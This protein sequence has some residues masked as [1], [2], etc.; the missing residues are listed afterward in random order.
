MTCSTATAPVKEV[1]TFSKFGSSFEE[2]KDRTSDKEVVS[3]L[4]LQPW[5]VVRRRTQV[6]PRYCIV[7]G[8]RTQV[9]PRYCIVLKC[10]QWH[11]LTIVSGELETME[12]QPTVKWNMKK[13]SLGSCLS[14]AL[15]PPPPSL[16]ESRHLVNMELMCNSAFF[17]LS[18]IGGGV[19]SS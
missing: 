11:P 12:F 2:V 5:I 1:S 9:Q 17:Y 8:R 4:V 16:C 15:R 10:D 3:R 6:Q 7:I 13:I 19:Y 18:F 14:V